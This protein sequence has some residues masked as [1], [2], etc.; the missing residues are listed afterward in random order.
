ME[1]APLRESMIDY[2]KDIS[3]F[4]GQKERQVGDVICDWYDFLYYPFRVAEEPPHFFKGAGERAIKEFD[5]SFSQKEREAMA[6]FHEYFSSI[7][8]KLRKKYD[9]EDKLE[10]LQ[11]QDFWIKFT[12]KAK[13][14]YELLESSNFSR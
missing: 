2:F 7:K 14:I 11:K 3:T 13:E 10:N 8:D 1:N 9:G 12:K 5:S 6:E 4:E